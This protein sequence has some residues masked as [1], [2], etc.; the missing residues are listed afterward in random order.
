M[1]DSDTTIDELK[2][3]LRV[4]CRVDFETHYDVT[5]RLVE[6]VAELEAKT[7]SLEQGNVLNKILE[8]LDEISG[9]IVDVETAV[10]KLGVSLHAS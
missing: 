8:K 2:E 5:T 3:I 9:G 1:I 7:E 6:I 4:N 10:E